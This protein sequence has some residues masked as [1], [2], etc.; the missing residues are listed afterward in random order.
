M[1][2]RKWPA[3]LCLTLA[4]V[5]NSGVC[6]AAGNAGRDGQQ[7][8]T[9]L[10]GAA[11]CF[12][13]AALEEHWG[14]KF[15][16]LCS[17]GR[18]PGEWVELVQPLAKKD[19]TGRIIL[20]MGLEEA[21][22][23][24]ISQDIQEDRRGGQE[25]PAPQDGAGTETAKTGEDRTVDWVRDVEKIG[26]LEQYLARHEEDFPP[27]GEKRVDLLNVRQW[28]E[29]AAR[30]R[31]L[32]RT[33]SV[34][35]TVLFPPVYR[36]KWESYTP[37]FL[38]E[39]RRELAKQVSYWDF[40]CTSLSWDSRYF[41][42]KDSFRPEVGTM[43]MARILGGEGVYY[44]Q[45]FGTYV[46]PGMAELYLKGLF[47]SENG[48]GPEEEAGYTREIPILMYHH[49]DPEPEGEFALSPQVFESHLRAIQASGFQTVSPQELIDYVYTGREL[50]AHP[51]L[52]TFDDGYLSN[53]ELAYPL[54]QKYNMKATIFI[55][56]SS[57]GMSS[58]KGTGS[59]ILPHFSYAQALEMAQSG[60]ITVQ[61][62]S[63]D[64]HQWGPLESDP[65]QARTTVAPLPG[66]TQ[67]E[68]IEAV[69]LDLTRAR[70]E[71]L[72]ATG[73]SVVSMAYPGGN[74]SDASELAIHQL[75][76]PL[77]V[78]TR[79]DS[80]NILVKGLP[81]SLYALCRWNITEQTTPWELISLIRGR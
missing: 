72:A 16:D 2:L 38:E 79:T 74:Y 17:G 43:M 52:I 31:T 80:R 61:T 75:G 7:K 55:I 8:D 65:D 11:A 30:I 34:E 73:I 5:L 64:M 66:E 49:L 19:S 10:V 40:A 26:A 60:L 58:Y 76:I 21:V 47:D 32:C 81:Q 24:H 67:E 63:Y 12:D 35:L 45:G 56:G 41:Y 20:I 29:A 57:V 39:Y 50:P 4:L 71:L 48:P 70:E 18:T 13:V 6:A 69:T 54:L 22:E 25:A 1:R 14:G 28:V 3:V 77:T 59:E 33:N 62:H 53:Y 78:S 23:S 46:T 44:P 37:K 27:A 9:Y 15:Y 68:F 51:V 42:D 36:E